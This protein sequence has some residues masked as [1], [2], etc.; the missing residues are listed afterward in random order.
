MPCMTEI[1]K[2]FSCSHKKDEINNEIC[3]FIDPL[4]NKISNLIHSRDHY[5][6]HSDRATRILC[7]LLNYIKYKCDN[8]PYSEDLNRWW[9]EHQQFDKGRYQHKE[10]LPKE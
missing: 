2:H 10:F 7:E 6:E 5:K 8:I 9:D 1:P 4:K 3:D